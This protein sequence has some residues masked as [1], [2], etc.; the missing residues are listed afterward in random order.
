MP[1]ER[2]LRAVALLF[3]G[4]FVLSAAP[5]NAQLPASAPHSMSEQEV[6]AIG[7]MTDAIQ[8]NWNPNCKVEGGGDIVVKVSFKLAPDGRIVGY[9]TAVGAERSPNPMVR[10]ETDRALRAVYQSAPFEGLPPD[11]YGQ[12]ITLNFKARDACAAR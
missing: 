11:Y 8:A 6:A 4:T 12:Q 3:A 10:A 9:P 1:T 2:L 5:A 7:R